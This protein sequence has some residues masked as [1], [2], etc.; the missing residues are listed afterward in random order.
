MYQTQE[1]DQ[2]ISL[3]Y[4]EQTRVEKCR[5]KEAALHGNYFVQ[6]YF[7]RLNKDSIDAIQGTLRILLG[8]LLHVRYLNFYLNHKLM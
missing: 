5:T 2:S 3:A 4:Q 7:L 1:Q 8:G 6:A